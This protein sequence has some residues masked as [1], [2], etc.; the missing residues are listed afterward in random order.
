MRLGLFA[1]AGAAFN[2]TTP[3]FS[4]STLGMLWLLHRDQQ[5]NLMAVI[6]NSQCIGKMQTA[7]VD[8]HD[9]S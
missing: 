6:R 2:Q 3:T 9:G 5:L 4:D 7:F 8:D 1:T